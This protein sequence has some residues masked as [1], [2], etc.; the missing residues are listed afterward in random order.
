M[1]FLDTDFAR[2][3]LSGSPYMQQR[4]KE[5]YAAEQAKQQM[6][7][8]DSYRNLGE[9]V[10]PPTASG[11]PA[12]GLINGQLPQGYWDERSTMQG[13][14]QIAQQ[15]LQNRQSGINQ[16]ISNQGAMERQMQDQGYRLNNID[17][18]DAARIQQQQAYWDQ[19]PLTEK[20]RQASAYASADSSNASAANTRQQTSFG[21]Q[22]H[23]LALQKAQAEAAKTGGPL[24]NQFTPQ[25]Q[26]EALTKLSMLDRGVAGGQAVVDWI[27]NRGTGA[28]LPG[29]GTGD[30]KLMRAEYEMSMVPMMQQ[31]YNSGT[32]NESEI[33]VFKELLG[34]PDKGL[35]MTESERKLI[36]GAVIR[37]RQ[38]REDA[39]SNL[40][41][42]TRS[43]RPSASQEV[44]SQYAGRQPQGTL[45]PYQP[46]Q[47]G[48]SE[49]YSGK[50][51]R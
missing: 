44:R 33:P 30:Y 16:G 27:D 34:D 36:K 21:A 19:K 42:P 4:E 7:L 28:S 8:L 47:P 38:L 31:L 35:T 41:L 45:K 22:L 46:P 48:Q 23:P 3:V 39:Y 50:V 6:G 32:L 51:Q 15:I 10:G 13:Q 2:L 40:G 5:R 14:E 29:V 25:Q 24:F 18:V 1:G 11:A 37:A 20:A 9:A 26:G 12:G 43:L 49:V 17:A